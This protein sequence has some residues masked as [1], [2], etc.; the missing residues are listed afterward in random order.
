ML[1]VVSGPRDGKSEPLVPHVVWTEEAEQQLTAISSDTTVDELL[2]L[3][4][5]LARFPQRGRHVPEL[6]DYP[7]YEII[8]EVILPR[9]ARLFYLFVSDSDEVIIL[10]LLP[11]G[12][13]F[14]ANV[15]GPRFETD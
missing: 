1:H 5:G 15:L 7:T 9:K 10:G 14:R 13:I 2:A 11:R 3:A 4:A 12:G 8:R 6:Q